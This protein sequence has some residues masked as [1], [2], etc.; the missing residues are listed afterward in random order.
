MAP[1]EV[2]STGAQARRWSGDMAAAYEDYL[3]PTVF[4]PFAVDTAARVATATPRPPERVLEVAAG[5]GAVARELVAAL[6]RA[7]VTATDLN[8]AMVEVGLARVPTATWLQADA[9]ALPWPE[10]VFDAVVCQFGV[11]FFPDRVAGLQEMARVLQPGGVLVVSTWG[12][13]EQHEPG[14]LVTRAV[15]KAL[16][17]EPPFLRS[18]PHGYHDRAQIESDVEAAGLELV[19]LDDVTLS[20]SSSPRKLAMGFCHGTPIR[21]A[22]EEAGDLET[23][24]KLVARRLEELDGP[25]PRQRSM[26]ALVITA[27]ERRAWDSNPR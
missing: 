11:M 21:A 12:P 26:T 8:P 17:G 19:S 10:A 15:T 7:S 2:E 25:A 22:L 23:L 6:P 18:I 13:L 4:A 3:V 27:R 1:A 5:T 14:W 9:L 16:G 20:A 24:T